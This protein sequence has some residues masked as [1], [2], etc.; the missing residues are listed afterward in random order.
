[1]SRRLMAL[2]TPRIHHDALDWVRRVVANG[3]SCSQ[4]TL[5]AVSAFCG[6]IDRAGIRDRFYRLGIF[7]GSNLAAAL[8][9]L[10]R[11]Q[12]FGGTTYGNAT[13]TNNNF[14]STDYSEAVG[15]D[16]NG[17]VSSGT[18]KFLDTGLSPDAMPTLAAG[19]MSVF[20]GDGNSGT[21]NGGLI[22]SRVATQFYYIRMT[23]VSNVI[24]SHWGHGTLASSSNAETQRCLIL[25][26]R[27]GPGQF[28]VY[29]NASVI[30]S[31]TAGIP[32]ANANS[33]V[34][35]NWRES[36][37]TVTAAN[38]WPHD[39]SAYSIGAAMT[40]A[41]VSAYHTALTTLLSALGRPT[42]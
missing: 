3:G 13:D 42:S 21:A 4:S 12:A 31:S 7:A 28:T 33:F 34:V 22:G 14:V 26:S 15:L 30:A 19:H 11:G 40:A 39:I 32:G 5:R 36:N 18:P 20:K 24:G 9:P 29:K 6:E 16:T 38:G 25:S 10:Y 27:Q 8:V 41:Q 1:M 17:T 37:G 23:A 2:A 35:F